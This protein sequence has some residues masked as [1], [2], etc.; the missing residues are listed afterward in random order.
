MPTKVLNVVP[1]GG[2]SSSRGARKRPRELSDDAMENAHNLFDGM[3]AVEDEANRAF[4][5]SLIFEGGGRA[6][7]YDPDETQSQD[8]MGYSFDEGMPNPFMEDQLGLGNSFPLVYE[9]PKDYDLDEENDEVEIDGEPLFD[10]LP[11]QTNAKNN[12]RKSKRTKAYTQNKDKL[13]CKCW[14]DIGQ[15]PKV[16][17]EQKAS[18]FWQRMHREFPERRKFKTY[19]MESKRGMAYVSRLLTY[20]QRELSTLA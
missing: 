1:V 10:E 8:G 13:L 12:K 6:I 11:V 19:Q 9:F 15:D 7:P 14:K 18:T 3:S 5:E 4:M 16:G 2:E 17:A 20:G